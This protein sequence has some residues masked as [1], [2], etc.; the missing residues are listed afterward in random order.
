MSFSQR[1]A[2]QV[3]GSV[4][5]DT[6]TVKIPPSKPTSNEDKDN[7]NNKD[8]TQNHER[9][10]SLNKIMR[11]IDRPPPGDVT[12]APVAKRSD[13]KPSKS[14]SKRASVAELSRQKSSLNFWEGAFSVQEVSPAKERIR[15]DALVMAEVKTNVIVSLS[16]SSPATVS[17]CSLF[18]MQD[19][20]NS[21]TYFYLAL[22]DK[23]RIHLHN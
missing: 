20:P 2:Q 10:Q 7:N 6:D 23:R 15:G 9:I 19:W 1:K 17:F 4:S 14:S 5:S 18:F 8:T 11:D 16:C 21:L 12:D 3:L 22:P 13:Q